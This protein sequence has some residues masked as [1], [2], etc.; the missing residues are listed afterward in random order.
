MIAARCSASCQAEKYLL[1]VLLFVLLF[2]LLVSRTENGGTATAQAA[3][4][5]AEHL[6]VLSEQ[7][8]M[9]LRAFSWAVC[10]LKN[11]TFCAQAA[12]SEKKKVVA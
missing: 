5:E 4:T 10:E 1:S 12:I 7:F 6:Q 8:R 3:E 2:S 11:Q 9:T